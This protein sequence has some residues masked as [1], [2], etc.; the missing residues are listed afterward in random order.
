M[1][2]TE[3]SLPARRRVSIFLSVATVLTL[4]WCG[5]N[6]TCAMAENA[7]EAQPTPPTTRIAIPEPASWKFPAVVES[8]RKIAPKN[9]GGQEFGQFGTAY[10]PAELD[11]VPVASMPP[12]ELQKYADIVTHA[13]PDAVFRQI[14]DDCKNLP[15]ERMNSTAFAGF[16]YISLHAI[17][18]RTREKAA[19]CLSELQRRLGVRQSSP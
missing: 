12:E 17:D 9:V 15:I 3:A 11:A 16:A 8:A 4:S 14:A 1:I 13:Y 19:A 6:C 10:S 18:P 7:T 5:S 2:L